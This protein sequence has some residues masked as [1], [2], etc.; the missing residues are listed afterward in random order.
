[1]TCGRSASVSG[2]PCDARPTLRLLDKQG[3]KGAHLRRPK[4]SRRVDGMNAAR[5][6]APFRQHVHEPTGP[7]IVR[8][9]GE[10]R[11]G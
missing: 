3:H 4:A 2:S 9:S 5:G 1:M 6:Q 7:E 8:D 11:W 10:M